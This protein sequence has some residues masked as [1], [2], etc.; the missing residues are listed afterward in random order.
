MMGC[1]ANLLGFWV[2]W[3]AEREGWRKGRLGFWG[4]DGEPAAVGAAG[5]P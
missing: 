1:R 3:R 2:E 4:L 5:G